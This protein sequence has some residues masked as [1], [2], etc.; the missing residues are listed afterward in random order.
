MQINRPVLKNYAKKHISETSPSPVVVALAYILITYVLELLYSNLIGYNKVMN[1][2]LLQ[3][4]NGNFDFVPTFPSISWYAGV[5]SFAISLMSFM[6][7]IGFTIFCLNVVKKNNP[8][9]GNLFDGF[10]IFLKVIWLQIVMS[11]FVFLWSLLLVVPGI[12]ASYR[13]RQALYIMIEDP[14]KGALQCIRESKEMMYGHKTELFVMDLSFIG[15]YLLCVVPF[16]SI[17]VMPYTGISYA[18]YYIALRDM[19]QNGKPA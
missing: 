14:S 11:V 13:Y 3:F 4:N 2:M 10:A 15:W 9:Y 17:W 7:S 8:N 12:I 5:T 6:L 19:P 18:T 16:V 1:E